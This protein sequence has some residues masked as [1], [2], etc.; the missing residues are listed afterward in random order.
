ML[1][2]NDTRLEYS[3]MQTA[4]PFDSDFYDLR[5][6]I[7]SSLGE[8]LALL[9]P[10]RA[11]QLTE[12]PTR[13]AG[14]FLDRLL[15]QGLIRSKSRQGDHAFLARLHRAEWE[16]DLCEDFCVNTTY[17]FQN[18]FLEKHVVAIDALEEEWNATDPDVSKARPT[19]DHFVEVGCG[20]GQVT[21]YMANRF[22]QLSTYTGIDICP[23]QIER[24]NAETENEQISFVAGDGLKWIRDNLQQNT[25]F[26]TNGGVLE[27]FA[28]AE[29]DQLF[30][31][32]K[33]SSPSMVVTIEP[34]A[35]DHDLVEQTES[36][37]FG[38][39][40]SFSHNYPEALRRNGFE[41]VF[42]DECRA[43][44]YRFVMIVSKA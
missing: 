6:S 9:L 16:Q 26:M 31:D 15:I 20:S 10:S 39:E 18:W 30:G 13:K 2:L 40:R 3:A 33:A 19:F 38:E 22:P 12:R 1:V 35:A 43:D 8:A 24:N 34:I 25:L 44:N 41:I 36:R 42:Q 5:Q 11:A 4:K 17:R 37:P 28:P 32:L 21:R 14:S 7:K 23:Q 27:Y 29:L